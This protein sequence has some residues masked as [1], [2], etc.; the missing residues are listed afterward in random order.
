MFKY[1]TNCGSK[2]P[3]DNLFCTNCGMKFNQ[4][5]NYNVNPQNNF[6]TPVQNTNYQQN[7]NRMVNT[8]MQMRTQ[9]N[10]SNANN[11]QQNQMQQHNQMINNQSM[12]NNQMGMN[13]FNIGKNYLQMNMPLPNYAQ[14]INYLQKAVNMGVKEASIYL[15]IAHL[16]QN[17]D[18]LKQNS[19]YIAE[20]TNGMNYIQ[21]MQN[22]NYGNNFANGLN[23][24]MMANNFNNRANNMPNNQAM[25]NQQMPNNMNNNQNNQE[26]GLKTFGKYAA[27]AAV[28]AMASSLYH[29]ATAEASSGHH[30]SLSSTEQ[31]AP[32]EYIPNEVTQPV[33][34]YI[35]PMYANPVENIQAYSEQVV[36]DMNNV[37]APEIMNSNVVDN[38]QAYDENIIPDNMQNNNEIQSSEEMLQENPVDS[39]QAYDET[40]T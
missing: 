3:A 37:V 25:A 8:N 12:N 31:P 39:I 33:Q 9:N 1:C 28:G 23:G 40:N 21:P 16:Y 5:N 22:A 35:D 7:A 6:T 2:M 10:Y 17:I 27:A 14:A 18:M 11:Y 13:E 15:M 29:N 4:E 32:T 19:M 24:N 34:D 38:I 26:S 30:S 20:H 36:P